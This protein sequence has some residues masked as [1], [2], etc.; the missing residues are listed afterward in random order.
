[1][2]KLISF[3][4]LDPNGLLSKDAILASSINQLSLIE[5][6]IVSQLY[7]NENGE[8]VY[9]DQTIWDMLMGFCKNLYN[10]K[11]I[12]NQ[13]LITNHTYFP[14]SADDLSMLGK[15]FFFIEEVEG[16]LFSMGNFKALG[17][18]GFHPI[19]FKKNRDTLGS[20][21]FYFTNKVFFN[22]E[23]ITNV[24]STQLTFI[25]KGIDLLKPLNSD[26]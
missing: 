14:I 23:L 20:S 19:F 8:W 6:I 18:D 12:V 17:L 9:D 2:K 5:D 25:P 26:P 10:S 7:K 16:A 21:I 3:S 1:M 22:L 13:T 11:G 4:N 24:N 15:E